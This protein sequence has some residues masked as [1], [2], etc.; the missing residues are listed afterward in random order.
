[1]AFL[2]RTRSPV[3]RQHSVRNSVFQDFCAPSSKFPVLVEWLDVNFD[4]YPLL[5]YPCRIIDK[6]GMLRLRQNKGKPPSIDRE[7]KSLYL[8][9][10]IF[11]VPKA[12]RNGS[13]SFPTITKI[14]ELDAMV[15]AWGGFVHTYCDL[16][17]TEVEFQ[18]M[19]DH[20]CWRKMRVKYG[21]NGVFPT[22]Y[23]KVSPRDINIS[24]YLQEEASWQKQWQ[25]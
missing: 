21:A 17:C 23:E 7:E 12:I 19:F 4:I 18:E 15:R 1:M 20:T 6:G 22:L 11:G 25:K 9:V 13:T 10:G 2:K 24:R 3:E 16:T 14:R 5:V 8:D